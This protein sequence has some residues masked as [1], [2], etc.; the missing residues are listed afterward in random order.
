MV[1]RLSDLRDLGEPLNCEVNSCLHHAKHRREL[2]ELISFRC[3]QWIS[4]EERNDL[5]PQIVLIE[6][7]IHEEIL[8]MIVSSAIQVH[9]SAS[10]V[11]SN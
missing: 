9:G 8:A 5:R 10:K 7:P 4:L 11:V 2:L 6:D 3:S 1:H